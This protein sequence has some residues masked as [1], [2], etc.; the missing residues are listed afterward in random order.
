MIRAFF[1]PYLDLVFFAK[2]FG[3]K[4]KYFRSDKKMECMGR[5]LWK[6]KCLPLMK[7]YLTSSNKE[8]QITTR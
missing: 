8:L 2:I 3:L 5:L 1:G 4:T 6:N 7:P